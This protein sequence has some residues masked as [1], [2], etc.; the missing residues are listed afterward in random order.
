MAS[1]KCNLGVR[2]GSERNKQYFSRRQEVVEKKKLD[3]VDDK[4]LKGKHADRDDKDIDNDG[5]VDSSDE[6]LHNRRATIKKSMK[7]SVE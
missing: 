2:H 7:H 5:D 4:E 6:Y 1:S 3:H